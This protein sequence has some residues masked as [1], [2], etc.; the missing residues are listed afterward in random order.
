LLDETALSVIFD[1]FY[2]SLYRYI[3]HHLGHQA[4]AEDLAAE[5]FARMLERLAEG[6]GPKRHLQAW[7][8]RVAHNLVVDEC[9]RWVH[10]DHMQLDQARI[11]PEPDIEMQAQRAVLRQKA[12]AALE[13]LTPKQ[14]AVL[15]LTILE[16][17]AD[18]EV[19][20]VM[21]RSVGAVKSLRRRGLAAM[22]RHL[23]QLGGIAER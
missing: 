15:I 21:N 20:R 9:R 4:S 19:A 14:R 8:Y 7:L 13:E 5:V 18:R 2:P 16:G 12:E 6:R 10:R 11:S 23:V 3:Y 22:R 17:Y 1:T